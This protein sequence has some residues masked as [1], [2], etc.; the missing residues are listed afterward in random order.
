MSRFHLHAASGLALVGLA[1][2]LSSPARAFPWDWDMVDN[3]F[4]RAYEWQMANLPDGA[5]TID[6]YV[7]NADRMTPEG[8]ALKNPFG[9]HPSEEVLAQ[10]KHMFE[11]YCQACHGVEGKGNAPVTH[12]DPANN[13]RRYPVPPPMLSGTGAI[14]AARSDGY[15]YLT[16]RNGGA[17]MPAYGPSMEDPEIWATV[18]YIR[19]LEGAQYTP[20]PAPS[21]APR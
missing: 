14:T 20:P 15:I 6:R 2:G 12:N 5:V 18:A 21:E 9:A 4:K 3:D 19:T 8:Q 13:V 11:V 7:P 1:A 16:I 17:I 10:G